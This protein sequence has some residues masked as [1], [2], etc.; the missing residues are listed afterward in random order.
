VDN[1]FMN[2]GANTDSLCIDPT[3]GGAF[4]SRLPSPVLD[5]FS[6]SPYGGGPTPT[7]NGV[8]VNTDIIGVSLK[9]ISDGASNTAMFSEIKQGGYNQTSG[10]DYAGPIRKGAW[11]LLNLC[12]YGWGARNPGGP[13]NISRYVVAAICSG[14]SCAASA[15]GNCRYYAGAYYYR[16]LPAYTYYYVHTSTHNSLVGDCLDPYNDGHTQSRSYHPGGVDTATCDG[17]VHFVK[18]T[19]NYGIWRALGTRGGGEVVSQDQTGF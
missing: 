19:I 6:T 16:A 15:G 17:G 10:G 11:D 4:N 1:Y 7:L 2:Y 18:E 5:S 9:E 12:C 8:P 3:T 14:N 13:E